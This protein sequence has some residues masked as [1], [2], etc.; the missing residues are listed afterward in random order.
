M[1]RLTRVDWHHIGLVG[2]A[3]VVMGIPAGA[4]GFPSSD[5]S[6][7]QEPKFVLSDCYPNDSGTAFQGEGPPWRGIEFATEKGARDYLFAVMSYVIEGNEE[8]FIHCVLG[9]EPAADAD[10]EARKVEP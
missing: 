6:L 4:W 9:G 2:I 3:A 8:T 10:A 7:D 1:N 5:D